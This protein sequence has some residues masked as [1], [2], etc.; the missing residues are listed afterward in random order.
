MKRIRK[1]THY[2]RPNRANPAKGVVY[3]AR[4]IAPCVTDYSGGE[5]SADNSGEL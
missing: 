5:F 3:D 2:I 1:L 4:G